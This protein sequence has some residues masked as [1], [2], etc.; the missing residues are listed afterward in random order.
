MAF[1]Q[2]VT[3]NCGSGVYETLSECYANGLQYWYCGAIRNIYAVM[4]MGKDYSPK[5]DIHIE[6]IT[7]HITRIAQLGCQ[8]CLFFLKNVFQVCNLL[9]W[10]DNR[11]LC[12]GM[13]THTPANAAACQMAICWRVPHLDKS[14]CANCY[15]TTY[16]MLNSW[17]SECREPHWAVG[18]SGTR[19]RKISIKWS[20]KNCLKMN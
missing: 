7:L 11:R 14:C 19:R 6:W 15:I 20:S 9:Y 10:K 17:C 18:V 12:V 3:C 8:N 4:V 16:T 2:V 13:H 1:A 5:V